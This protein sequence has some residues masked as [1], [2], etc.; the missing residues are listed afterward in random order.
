MEDCGRL[1]NGQVPPF[2]RADACQVELPGLFDLLVVGQFEVLP[3]RADSLDIAGSP[4]DGNG[5]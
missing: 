5:S 3:L 1:P 2:R 4:S